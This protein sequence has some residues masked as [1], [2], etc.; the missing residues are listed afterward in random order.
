MHFE[1]IA[2]GGGVICH[3]FSKKTKAFSIKI[4]KKIRGGVWVGSLVPPVID[5]TCLRFWF[6]LSSGF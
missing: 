4:Y 6:C 1:N 2:G 5:T 3:S